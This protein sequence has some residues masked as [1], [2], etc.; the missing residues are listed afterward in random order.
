MP[1]S[2]ACTYVS[3]ALAFGAGLACKRMSF[4]SPSD[5]PEE[6]EA[7]NAENAALMRSMARGDRAAFG[8]LYDRLSKPLYATARRILNDDKEVR[9][10]TEPWMDNVRQLLSGGVRERNVRAAYGEQPTDD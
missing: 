1:G 6:L 9:V 2:F 4:P 10:H 3:D 5:R 7:G 8:T